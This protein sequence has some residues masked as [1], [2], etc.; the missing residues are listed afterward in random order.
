MAKI[1][2]VDDDVA[3][4]K[5][6]QIHLSSQGYEIAL[7][8]SVDAGLETANV[9]NPDLI[10]LDIRMPGRSGLEGLPDFKAAHPN[11]RVIMITAFHDMESTIQAMQL[12]AED[13]IHKPIDIDELD[14]AVEKL[15]QR[16]GD[17]N[18]HFKPEKDN[19]TPPMMV[20]R[21]R[22]MKEVFKTIGLVA[23]SSATILISGE[24][25]TGKEL[26]ARAIHASSN[27]PDGPFVALNCAA[28]VDSLLES[29]M[30]GHEKGSFTGAIARQ[31][32]K[33]ALAENGTIFLDEIGEMSPAMQAKLLRA[34]QYK[35]FTPVG[36]KQVQKTD[37]RIIAATN[38]NLPD[39]VAQGK[40]REDLFYRLQVVNI[41]LPPLR[42]RKDDIEELVQILLNR[43]NRELGRNVL[44]ISRDLMQCFE[45]YH[46]PGNVR[47]LENLLMKAV[48]LCPSDTLMVDLMPSEMCVSSKPQEDDTEDR[49]LSLDEMEGK[50]VNDILNAV[51]WHKGKACDILGISRP[52]LRRIIEH[53]HLKPEHVSPEDQSL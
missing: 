47:E 38:V 26:V 29:E 28:V 25:G 40:F 52:R 42:E 31:A 4:G 2:I 7:A 41:A 14:D 1:L 6:L 51:Q 36:A 44:Q 39:L 16:N 17:D 8:N 9:F 34:I 23:R 22:A 53:H 32:G 43:V 46:W 45:N 33:F 35:E 24:S 37:A 21:S 3:G 27:N 11:A 15:L 19:T 49:L 13:Y 18:E 48:A 30:F 50:H 20:G 5:T 10:I 12:G